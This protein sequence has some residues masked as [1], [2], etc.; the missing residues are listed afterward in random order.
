[1]FNKIF[2][3]LNK[4]GKDKYQHFTLGS[5]IACIVLC[6]A[7]CLDFPVANFI[8]IASVFSAALFKEF[9]LDGFENADIMDIVAT[10]LGGLPIWVVSSFV[11]ANTI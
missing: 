8:S 11:Y 5:L 6:L 1:M 10:L 7:S 3:Y 4:I 9:S 2:K